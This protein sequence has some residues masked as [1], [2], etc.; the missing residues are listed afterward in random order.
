MTLYLFG[1]VGVVLYALFW[2]FILDRNRP[3]TTKEFLLKILARVVFLLFVFSVL[4]GFSYFALGVFNVTP[5][6]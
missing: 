2:S 4:V 5:E 1:A 3:S 6:G